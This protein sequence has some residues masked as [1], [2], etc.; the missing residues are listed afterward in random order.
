MRPIRDE[1]YS[2]IRQA[3]IRGVYQ[4]G[5][6]LQE[7]TLAEQLGTSR[8]PVREA[9]RKLEIERLV[10]YYPHRGTVVSEVV[11]DEIEELYQVRILLETMIAKRAAQNATDEDIEHLRDLLEQ[12]KKMT[13]SDELLDCIEQFNNYIFEMASCDYLV[14]LNKRAHDILR[15][16]MTYNALDEERRS[17]TY[18]EH[19][20]I[21]DALSKHDLEAAQQATAEHILASAS[22][23]KGVGKILL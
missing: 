10:V 22:R 16:A 4:P 2:R 19:C 3:I 8:T 18:T 11:T 7:E 23:I 20:R 5:D 21:V 14:D 13:D 12:S 6:R 1:V 17:G 9:L 15:R